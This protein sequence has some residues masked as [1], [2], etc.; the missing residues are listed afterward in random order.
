MYNL[1]TAKKAVNGLNNII[2]ESNDKIINDFVNKIFDD[3][4]LSDEQIEKINQISYNIKDDISK[5]NLLNLLQKKKKREGPKKPPTE[6]NLFIQKKMPGLKEEFPN[7][8]Q[9]ILLSKAA[10][11]WN[12]EKNKKNDI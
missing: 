4:D 5:A 3:L 6:Y 2:K 9:S 12:E 11:L 1:N 8:K 7:E 10:K